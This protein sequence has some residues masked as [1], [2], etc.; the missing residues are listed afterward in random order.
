MCVCVS[1]WHSSGEVMMAS[2]L[3]TLV[4]PTMRCPITSKKLKKNDII[5]LTAGGTSFSAHNKVIATKYTPTM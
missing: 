4:E 2:C 3:K 5:H 1:R